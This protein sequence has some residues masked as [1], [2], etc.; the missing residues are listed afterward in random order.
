M[1]MMD[2]TV[3]SKERGYKGRTRE[4][5]VSTSWSGETAGASVLCSAVTAPY[6]M[7]GRGIWRKTR[8]TEILKGGRTDERER[9][10]EQR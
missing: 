6:T 9:W 3:R 8:D 4:N 2:V 1:M 5:R 7:F 10:G